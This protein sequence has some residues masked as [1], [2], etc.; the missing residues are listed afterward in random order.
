MYLHLVSLSSC[1]EIVHL[2]D[3]STVTIARQAV[4]EKGEAL[5]IFS[6]SAFD[7]LIKFST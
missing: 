6:C 2:C 4:G 3:L 7:L 1:D 5:T